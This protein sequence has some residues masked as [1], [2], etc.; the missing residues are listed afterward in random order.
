ME[1]WWPIIAPITALAVNVVAQIVAFRL[2]RGR[3]FLQSV[4]LGFGVGLLALILAQLIF[5]PGATALD[6]WCTALLV[7]VPIYGALSYCFFNFA[8]LGQ[9]SIRVR[10]YARIAHEPRG[11]SVAELA[12]EY[13]EE[14]LLNMRLQRLTESGDIALTNGRY[15]L[16]RKRFVPVAHTIFAIKRFVLG[17]TS[18]FPA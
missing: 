3:R 7:N 1:R 5:P 2:F 16:G 6:A 15:F 12:A 8:N 18:E 9:S 13:N 17:K 11:L 14:S 4:V 10:I